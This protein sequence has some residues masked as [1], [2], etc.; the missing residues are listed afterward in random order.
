MYDAMSEVKHFFTKFGGHAMAAGLSMAVPSMA[1]PSMARS[2]TAGGAGAEEEMIAAF[3]REINERCSLTEEDFTARVHIDVPMPL[4][5]A[6][7][8]L[9]EELNLLEP[10]GVGNP[11]PLFAEKDLIFLAGYR[12]GAKKNFA[13]Y[14]VQTPS[15]SRKQLVY[16]GDLESFGSFLNEK[17]GP[18]S[19]AA[20]YEGRARLKISVVYQLGKNTYRGKQE[21]QYIMQHFDC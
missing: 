9:A 3:R 5:Y 7:E 4:D 14:T 11:R 15:G 21:L 8:K 10:F 6:S 16:F 12:M 20:L 17:Y 1:V 2:S 19:E 18:G 13:R